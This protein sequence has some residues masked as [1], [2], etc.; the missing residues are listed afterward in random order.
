MIQARRHPLSWFLGLGVVLPLGECQSIAPSPRHEVS[1]SPLASGPA[2]TGASSSTSLPVFVFPFNSAKA[3]TYGSLGQD[4][5]KRGVPASPPACKGLSPAPPAAERSPDTTSH[6]RCAKSGR[7]PTSP[8][9]PDHSP[10]THTNARMRTHTHTDIITRTPACTGHNPSTAR[11]PAPCATDR[12][13]SPWPRRC[14]AGRPARPGLDAHREAPTRLA[15]WGPAWARPLTH[16]PCAVGVKGKAFGPRHSCALQS[17]D[18]GG[19]DCCQVQHAVTATPSWDQPC[20][21]HLLPRT[22][23]LG[24]TARPSPEPRLQPPGLRGNVWVKLSGV[25]NFVPA[26]LGTHSGPVAGPERWQGPHTVD[27]RNGAKPEAGGQRAA[28]GVGP[29]IVCLPGSGAV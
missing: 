5:T 17:P 7:A 23:A 22:E 18:R 20:L 25:W 21:R 16:G 6:V 12:P 26:A 2:W 11:P 29:S 24:G 3:E 19:A 14:P 27:A 10:V 9:C 8:N 15:E 13:P 28:C 1:P 4:T